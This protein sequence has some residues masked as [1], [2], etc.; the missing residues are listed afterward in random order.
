VDTRMDK[1][2]HERVRIGRVG[3]WD[4][5]LNDYYIYHRYDFDNLVEE[6]GGRFSV[7]PTRLLLEEQYL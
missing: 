6:V 2:S 5:Y 1:A 3:A 4:S 7:R